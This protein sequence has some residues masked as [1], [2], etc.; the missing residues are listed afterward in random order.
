MHALA[1][2]AHL[3]FCHSVFLAN[4]DNLFVWKKYHCITKQSRST[5]PFAIADWL[6][7]ANGLSYKYWM[8]RAHGRLIHVFSLYFHHQNWS[9]SH[10]DNINFV[11]S[12]CITNPHVFLIH[13]ARLSFTQLWPWN[14]LP[15]RLIT[16]S[17]SFACLSSNCPLY[18][19]FFLHSL[20]LIAISSLNQSNSHLHLQLIT[21]P[22]TQSYSHLQ[23]STIWLPSPAHLPS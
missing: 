14:S 4:C 21:N 16:S 5:K 9:A 6:P 18:H 23:L 17:S 1:N 2:P 12:F 8:S 11:S 3:R 10:G 13:S 19:P 15:N 22:F 7:L 20:S